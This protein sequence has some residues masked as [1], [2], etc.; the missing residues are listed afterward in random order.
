MVRP[1]R[2]GSVMH[3]MSPLNFKQESSIARF[4]QICNY[5]VEGNV[6]KASFL[7]WT[8]EPISRQPRRRFNWRR[9]TTWP[10]ASTPWT[11][12]TDLLV[13]PILRRQKRSNRI[14]PKI[15]VVESR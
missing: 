12:K 4:Y 13:M 8:P 7:D 3:S 5:L 6:Y 10:T 14:L 2:F 11:W 1:T 15:F 9:I